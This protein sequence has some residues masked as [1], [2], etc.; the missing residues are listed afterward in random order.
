MKRLAVLTMLVVLVNL[1]ILASQKER[2]HD[3]Q[4]GGLM[5]T[6]SVSAQ[7]VNSEAAKKNVAV[8]LVGHGVPAN[9]FPREKLSEFRRVTGQVM[10]AGGE[11]K[12]PSE[13]VARL[14][15]LEHEVRQWKRTPENDPY[16]T[17]VQE[18]AVQIKQ[19]GGYELVEVAHNEAC[20][21]D[22]DEAIDNVIKKGATRILVLTTMII[23]GGA[24]AEHD[25]ARKVEK[26]KRA[27]PE[28]S[29]T[30]VW[31]IEMDQVVQFFATQ[32]NRFQ[33]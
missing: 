12:A 3:S 11:E 14:Q 8:V 15:A 18:L 24:H 20:G 6:Q 23:K 30:Y 29:I 1:A 27:H 5:P 16:N 26:A 31:P 21:L 22:V 33:P 7:V 9:D 25:I 19:A 28:A 2:A 10:A 17:T 4:A 32:L 13:L